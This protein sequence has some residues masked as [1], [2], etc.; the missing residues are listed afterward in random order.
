MINRRHFLRTT[1]ASLGVGAGFAT[2]LA[3]LNAFAADTDDYKALVCVFLFGAMDSH[4]MVIPYD[5]SSYNQ[6][7]TIREPVLAGYD[8]VQS[9]RRSQLLQL[10]G[11]VG[12]RQFAFP[13]EYAQLHQ[14]YQ[15]G[16]LAIVGNIGPMIEPVNKQTY[17]SGAARRPA[18]LFSHNDQ[19]STWMA[20]RP[21]GATT[22]WGG[23]F[24]DIMQAAQ[25]NTQA[26]FTAMSVSGN[27]VFLTGNDV[28]P[29]VVSPSGAATVNG[30]NQNF[31]LGS[32]DF[33]DIYQE[34]L[35]DTGGTRSNLFQRDV[36]STINASLNNNALL[37][38]QLALP[39]D[40]MTSF[41]PG[42]LGSQLRMVARSIARRNT[43]GMKR[44]VFFVST[45]GFDTHSAQATD[46]PVL[47]ADIAASVRA[48]HDSM[49]EMGIENS[50][51]TFTAS[52]FG[53]TLGVNGD[54]TDHGWGSH[55]IV[56][57]GAVNGG[58]VHGD[59]PPP[60]L[61]HN[62]DAGRGRLIPQVSVDQYAAALGSWFG[63]TNGE[64]NEAIPGLTNFDETA[65]SG[66][67]A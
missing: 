27:S 39:G 57:G 3:S 10:A 62:Q 23:R 25:A 60:E 56:V 34:V 67:F 21:E 63:L 20:S 43:L 19:Q 18:K 24:A 9:R 66:L 22:G 55:H 33:N 38:E 17:D 26:A 28:Q 42:R 40:P 7:E 13:P 65:L 36:I 15:Q 11:D 8:L 64:L 6:F 44:Q 4:D 50:V 59:V 1:C 14:L 2:N 45:G 5:Q 54:G 12:G 51:T 30:L 35:R 31:T 37:E 47:Q 49:V 29:F 32:R 16:D 53:R 61:G 41:P 52:D 58:Q 48:F 46:L